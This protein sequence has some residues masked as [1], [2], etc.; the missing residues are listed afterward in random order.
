MSVLGGI[1]V[2][3]YAGI[4]RLQKDMDDAKSIVGNSMASVK[5]AITGALGALGAGLSVAAFAQMIKGA[6]DAAEALHDLSIQTG[7]SVESLSAF[8][9]VGKTSGTSAQDIAGAMNKLSKT[10]AVADE[11]S[12]GAGAAVKA[13]GL[14]FESFRRM[15]PDD[16]MLTLAKAMD[17]FEDGGAK[18]AIAMTLMGKSGAALLP[19]MKDLANTGE[20]VAAVTT[21]QAAAADDYSDAITRSGMRIDDLQRAMAMRLLP[22]MAAVQE[23][24][25]DLGTTIGDYLA[26][27]TSKAN[28]RFGVM[29]GVVR[30]LGTVMEFLVL[31]ASDVVFVFKGIGD[32]IG[33]VAAVFPTGVG[34]NRRSASQRRQTRKLS[35]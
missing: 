1:E 18:S 3:I 26:S 10:M 30:T 17:K 11:S 15:K 28:E 2:Q 33:G 5:S 16:Q 34:M 19:Y 35:R 24:A 6:I 22:T 23:L 13:L 32:T 31:L 27:G 14:D 20:L 25:A 21:E 8:A 7:A 4:G 9:R 29:N 12:K